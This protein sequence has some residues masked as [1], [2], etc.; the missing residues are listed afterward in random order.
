M[1]TRIEKDPQYM[2][3]GTI[4]SVRPESSFWSMNQFLSQS[5]K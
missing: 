3:T 1:G 4:S 5:K 2:E